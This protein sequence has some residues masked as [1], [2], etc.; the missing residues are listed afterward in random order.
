MPRTLGAF[1]GLLIV[2]VALACASPAPPAAPPAAPG[3]ALTGDSASA[4]R[5]DA[6]PARPAASGAAVPA[7]AGSAKAAYTISSTSMTPLWLAED[8]GLWKQHGLDVDLMLISGMPPAIAALVAGEVQFVNSQGEST[9]SAQAREPEVVG[10][11]NWVA[12]GVQRFIARPEIARPEDLR[13]KRVG[14]FSIGDGHQA[15]WGKVLT[16]W[17]LDPQRDVTYIA[18]GGGN[19]GAFVAALSA[20]A[21]DAAMFTPPADALALRNGGHVLGEGGDLIYPTGG[22]PVFTRRETIE[23]RRP[24]AEA[25][26]KGVVDAIRLFKGNPE[27]AKETIARRM[28]I[29]DPEMVA[30]AYEAY[31]RPGWMPERPFIDAELMRQVIEAVAEETPDVRAVDPTRAYDNSVLQALDAQGFLPPP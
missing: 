11:A 9:L 10:I 12:R 27:L 23:A 26:L 28:Q 22:I 30:A 2:V 21:V 14:V 8:Q 7:F 29:T 16:K 6:P 25:Y 17:G 20:G 18:V 24:L 13:G 4:A 19:M 1:G 31:A 3:V 15:Y 5:A